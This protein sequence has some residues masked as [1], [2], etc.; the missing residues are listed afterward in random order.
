MKLLIPCRNVIHIVK[1]KEILYC[2]SENSYTAVVL[3]NGEEFL[4]SK[5]LSKMALELKSSMFMK[6]SQTY[7]INMN[8][9]N[10]IDKEKKTIELYTSEPIRFTIKIK[11]LVDFLTNMNEI[12]PNGVGTSDV[13]LE[14][15][16]I[17]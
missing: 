17:I 5:P 12:K 3:I 15:R 11:T 10:K 2:R 14:D 16:V 7:L 9:V 4:L 8:Q 1:Y 13:S 6:V